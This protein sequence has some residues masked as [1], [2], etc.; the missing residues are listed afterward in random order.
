[1]TLDDKTPAIQ[2][3]SSSLPVTS[4]DA[5]KDGDDDEVSVCFTQ[6]WVL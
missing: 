3:H 2:T 4:L 1:M 6:V 5:A